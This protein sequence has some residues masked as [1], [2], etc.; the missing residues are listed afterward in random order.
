MTA[1]APSHV[2]YFAVGTG[3][4]RGTFTFRVTSWRRFLGARGLGGLNRLLVVAM[5]GTRLVTGASR[6]DSTIVARPDAGD[7]G[8]ADNTVRLSAFGV[9]LYLLRERYVLDPDGT[10][11]TVHAHERFGPLPRVMTRTFAYPAEI[12]EA[13]MASTYHMPLLGTAWTA[14]YHVGADRRSLAGELVCDWA[15]ATERARRVTG[16]GGGTEGPE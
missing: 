2:Y 10:R 6:L 15:R 14:T 13:G 1:E 8:E 5:C 4:W 12:R 7:F 11:V 9:P 3:V 16:G